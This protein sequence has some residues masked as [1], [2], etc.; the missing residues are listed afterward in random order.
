[1]APDSAHAARRGRLKIFLGAAPGVGKTYEM[2]LTA[3]QR[4]AEGVDVVAG[5]V[6]THGR[7][8]TAALLEG[9]EIIPQRHVAIGSQVVAEMDLDAI[10]ARHPQ[11]V[12]VDELAHTN[13]PGS[14]HPKRYLDVEELIAAGI[15][16]LT[17]LNI[18]H[19]ESLNDVVARI[20]RVRVREIV[21]DAV[22]DAAD[23]I[24]VIDLSADDLIRRLE[25]GKVYAPVQA[26]RALECFFSK[27]NLTALRELALRRTAQRVDDDLLHHMR[28][29]AIEGPWPA[30]ERLLVCLGSN[31]TAM[32]L[33]RHGKRLADRQRIPWMALHVETPTESGK[34]Q[35]AR[36]HVSEALRLTERL[37]GEA[38]SLPGDT[39]AADVLALAR[40]RNVTQ[41]VVGKPHRT[42]GIG[43][44]QRSLVDDLVRGADTM[45]VSVVA[46]AGLH[47]DD[48]AA[49]PRV[50]A[51][52]APTPW[53]GYLVACASVGA[54]TLIGLLVQPHVGL[55]TIDLVYLV[56]VV[57]IAVSFGIGPSMLASLAGSLAYNF[58]FIPPIH[59]LDIAAPTNI[60]AFVVFLA[61][62][63]VVSQLAARVRSQVLAARAR[64][65]TT[66][67]LYGFSR[68][69]ADAG[70]LDDL[71]WAIAFQIASMLKL[72]V[73]LLMP[74]GP[75]LVVRA[76]YPP[77]D[78]LDEADMG[79]ARWA[80]DRGRA[81]GRGAD[82]LPGAKRLFMPL[83]TARSVV[84][85]AGLSRDRP[86]SLLSQGAMR[87]LEALLD[88]AAVAIERIQLASGMEAARIDAETERLRASLLASL[89]HD[90]KTPLASIVGAASSLRQYSSLF[91]ARERDELV[92][93]IDGE[94]QRMARFVSNLLDLARLESGAVELER[95]V[96]DLADQ[97]GT[98]LQRAQGVL[99][100]RPIAIDLPADL[101][102]VLADAMLLEQVLMNLLENAAKYTP[103]GSPLLI[104]AALRDGGL[105][106]EVMDEGPGLPSTDL[107]R[108]FEKYYRAADRDRRPAGAGLGLAIGRGF[109]TAIGGRLTA[110]NRTDRPGAV[111][112]V[113]FPAPLIV[114]NQPKESSA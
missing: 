55:E 3:R 46:A 17:T 22:I 26:Q 33:V 8:D 21:P 106:L 61:V 34:G 93:T 73:V 70:S 100:D 114:E 50:V 5:V 36:D 39:I 99:G 60:A 2:L 72:E 67:A 69:I 88:Q 12:L 108:I 64:A 53:A 37:G 78:E 41:I 54:A 13:A 79:A 31:D 75:S 6:E 28:S 38:V 32:S 94:A 98:A 90:L 48:T 11:L 56:G 103:A 24:E 44:F 89:S 62:A 47:P 82:T 87:L 86:G 42:G 85:V 40:E 68:K 58:F 25:D 96:V 30:G 18:Q 20:T 59:T 16:V 49:D 63:L 95:V 80:Y 4:L 112:T 7:N 71:L 109:M 15:D 81:A 65:R 107:D 102:L 91:D 110:A 10:L 43:W 74:E 111:F 27:G 105:A 52:A 92:A 76:A 19:V 83:R 104:M 14:R 113:F 57:G 101:P 9:L 51:A 1:M 84:A 45:T 66:E 23:D 77:D 35:D 97:V 29:H